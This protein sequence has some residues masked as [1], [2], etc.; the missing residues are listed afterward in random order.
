MLRQ[1][2]IYCVF[3]LLMSATTCI[4]VFAQQPFVCRGQ[5]FLSLTPQNAAFSQMYRVG[6]TRSGNLVNLETLSTNLTRMVNAMGYRVKDNFIYGVNPFDATLQRVGSDGIAVSLGVP[7]GIPR[8]LIYFAGDVTPDGRFLILIGINTGISRLIKVDLDDPEYAVTVI[9]LQ[10]N[11]EILDIAFDPYTGQLYGHDAL[12]QRLVIID[13]DTGGLNA[14][15]RRGNELAQLGALFFDSYGNL[16]G[17]GSLNNDSFDKFVR[18]NKTSGDMEVLAI[19]PRTDGQDGCACP[20]TLQLNKT[21]TPDTAYACTEVVYDFIVSNAS[22]ATRFNI[23]LRDQLPADLIPLS[24]VKNPFGGDVRINSNTVE[25]N[26]MTVPIGIDTIK[27]AVR[28]EDG[29]S[30]NY[31]NQASLSGLPVTLGSSVLSDNPRSFV[32]LDSTILHVL[33]KDISFFKDSIS[34]CS[35]EELVYD[36]QRQGLEYQ[37]FDGENTGSRALPVPGQYQVTVTDA[38][39]QFAYEIN[40]EE[41]FSS[42]QILNDNEI[43]INLGDSFSLT[44]KYENDDNEVTFQWTGTQDAS[45][46]CPQCPN[47]DVK[48]LRNEIIKLTMTNSLGCE[49]SDSVFVR[50]L[51][52]YVVFAPN[53]IMANGNTPNDLFYI[54]G[55]QDI[56]RGKKLLIFDRWG[57]NIFQSSDFELNNP[58]GGWD[59]TFEGTPVEQGVY[60]W[61]AT[62]RFINGTE[63]VFAGDLTVVRR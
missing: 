20:F 3:I 47:T 41:V 6:T 2:G 53:I 62:I 24:I 60:T 32:E 12:S 11:V 1:C 14:N 29:A 13:P 50:V 31:A 39:E 23:N 46:T 49:V 16:F 15:F 22:G 43:E 28:I 57:N 58:Q 18:I 38:C 52:D 54:S 4:R 42:V 37:W 9:P 40:V 63:R 36:I 5:Y 30:G 19:G 44:S 34:V 17:Y 10:R 51:R 61:V 21:V 25:I 33:P 26:R 8:N 56:S 59:G 48:S 45:F 55:N 7:R 35:G 27:L